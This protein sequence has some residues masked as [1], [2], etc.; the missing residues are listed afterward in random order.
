[1]KIKLPKI[2]TTDGTV[3]KMTDDMIEKGMFMLDEGNSE[4]FVAREL[5]VSRHTVRIH[6]K[7][8]YRELFRSRYKTFDYIKTQPNQ[9]KSRRENAKKR[10]RLIA[11]LYPE[12]VK[13]YRKEIREK[14][15]KEYF[16]L[17]LIEF[18]K[19]HPDYWKKYY[20]LPKQG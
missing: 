19:K 4:R 8:G 6:C 14:Y 17:K 12:E 9:I 11:K 2:H 5:G 16:R 7:R 18:R 20:K 15:G 3:K 1:M 10:A 13:E